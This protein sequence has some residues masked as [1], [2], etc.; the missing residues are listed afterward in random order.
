M[1]IEICELSKQYK[2]HNALRNLS[3][4]VPEGSAFVVVGP[5]GA[6]KTTMIKILMNL[7]E[8]TSGT[9]EIFGV[10]SRRL[11]PKELA[12]IGYV[13]ENQELPGRLTVAEYLNYLRPFYPQW[14]R[15]LEAETLKQF[16][17]PGDRKINELSHGMRVK[18]ALTCALPY[19]PKLLVLDEPFSGLDPLVR[20]EFMEGMAGYAQEMTILISSH[21]LSEVEGFGTDVAFID[22][23]TLLFQESMETL[24][25]RVQEVRVTVDRLAKVLGPAP[26]DWTD[27]KESGNMLTF[28][29]TQFVANDL[30][31][32]VRAHVDGVERVEVHAMPLRTIFTS[33]ARATRKQEV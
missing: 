19:R 16:R 13:S 15:Q 32:Q 33:L 23:G 10:D 2:N 1:M 20:D 27:V 11:S 3:L 8:A 12:Q 28:V 21:E 18:L 7:L 6:G 31:A 17:L 29:H 26:T 30:E 14:D 4:H 25:G 24:T 22:E 9:A 5:N